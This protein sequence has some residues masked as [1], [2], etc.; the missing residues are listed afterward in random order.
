MVSWSHGLME[1]YIRVHHGTVY[2]L[3]YIFLFFFGARR[4]RMPAVQKKAKKRKRVTGS[5]LSYYLVISCHSLVYNN[6]LE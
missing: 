6:R 4:R 5:S 1:R 2:T 3:I